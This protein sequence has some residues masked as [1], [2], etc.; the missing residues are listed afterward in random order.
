M[1]FSKKCL[2]IHDNRQET[3]VNTV[4]DVQSLTRQQ[5]TE[6]CGFSLVLYLVCNS[7]QNCGYSSS[8]FYHL[9]CHWCV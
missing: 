1:S 2:N 3:F 9:L 4:P 8:C 6:L 5:S 7:W